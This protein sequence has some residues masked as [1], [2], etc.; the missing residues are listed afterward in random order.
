MKIVFQYFFKSSLVVAV[1]SSLLLSTSVFSSPW[2]DSNFVS[3]SVE[4][5]NQSK[6]AKPGNKAVEPLKYRSLE[7]DEF[8][9]KTLL[10]QNVSLK[11][12]NNEEGE[13]NVVNKLFLPLPDG[14]EVEV[15]ATE[16]S[17]LSPE[18]AL[19]F[20]DI[21]TWRVAGVDQNLTGRIDFT[22]LGF[23]GML[24]L[25][26]GDTVFIEPDDNKTAA[27]TLSDASRY[28][29][30]SKHANHDHFQNHFSCGVDEHQS[31]ILKHVSPALAKGPA[32]KPALKHITYRLAVATTG[33]YTKYH[34]GTK[35]S[36]LSAVTT[37]INRVNEIYERDLS[38]TLQL[39]PEQSKVIYTNADT[40]PYT[41]S[42]ALKLIEANMSNMATT[43]GLANFD[44]G[45]VFSRGDF[46]GLAYLGV[47]CV[48]SAEDENGE[49]VYGVKAGGTT[50]SDSPIGDAFAV[51]YVAHE[52]GHQLGAQHTFNSQWCGRRGEGTAVEP[53]SGSTIMSYAGLCGSDDLQDKVD[54]QFHVVSI[55]EIMANTRSGDGSSCGVRTPVTNENP[56][57]SAGEDFTVPA[58]TPIV[59]IAEASDIDGD[60]LTYS[61]EQIDSG[62]AGS[63]NVDNGDG[64][65]FRSRALTSSN[66]R[67]IPQLSDVFKGQASNGEYL[68]VTNRKL[69][70]MVTVRDGKGGVEADDVVMNVYD[71]GSSFQVTS[72][73]DS[74]T[75]N[76]GDKTTIT[77]DVAG[78]DAS[79]ISCRTVDIGLITLDG[80]GI[81]IIT[82]PNDGSQKITIPNDISAL[83]NA[84]FIVSCK[85]N[86]FFSVSTGELTIRGG[87]GSGSWGYLTLLMIPLYMRKRL[88]QILSGDSRENLS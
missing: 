44:I 65:L 4:R 85:A 76:R 13:V 28:I 69:N 25:P 8:A 6:A 18:L 20:P 57:V 50:A 26:N 10:K 41:S 14:T 29:S 84:R 17:V 63:L 39:I 62:R 21:K 61:W 81:D 58:R 73:S 35:S 11:P 47:A 72:H 40:D 22:E 68:P 80:K 2:K 59:L 48:D 34:G 38:I 52:M 31:N 42:E 64:A 67:F 56:I 60:A 88:K 12:A 37:I 82:T 16:T 55:L 43:I 24:S 32:L 78:T 77:W 36:A 75:F 74:E 87:S 3:E 83:S 9:W 23:H 19:Q 1:I 71:T 66:M 70:M 7:L 86:R 51:D 46:G 54:A 15:I 49:T 30:F 79:P 5:A 45:H 53:G 33:E 27:R